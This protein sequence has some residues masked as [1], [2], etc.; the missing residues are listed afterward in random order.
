MFELPKQQVKLIKASTP[1]ENHGNDYKLACVLTV[2]AT[3]SN[4][5]LSFFSSSLRDALYR[6]ATPEDGA[7]L[8]TDPDSPSVLR[9]PKMSPFAWDWTGVGYKAVVDYGLGGDSDI[10]LVD[11][12]LDAFMVTPM[13]GG[14]V[15]LKFNVIVHPSALDTGRLC[16]KQKQNIDLTLI[17]PAPTTV[18]E[19]F[20]EE[21]K[22]A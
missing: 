11:A 9:F 12:K 7:D 8:A 10:T 6:M 3:V 17:A 15:V 16:E 5:A 13:E 14:S 19:L 22:A 20:N 18:Q 4:S 21:A 2:E 1:I